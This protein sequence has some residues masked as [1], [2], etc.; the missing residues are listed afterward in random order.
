M[1]RSLAIAAALLILGASAHGTQPPQDNAELAKLFREDQ[2]D[3]MPAAGKLSPSV[4]WSVVI[5]RDR[6]REK[7]VKELIAADSLGTGSDYYHAA[8]VLQHAPTPDDYLLAHDL[9]V[10]A[11]ARGEE[12]PFAAGPVRAGVRASA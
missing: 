9:C 8:M 12:P 7:R 11:I 5:P 1:H 6:A 3:R 10:V 2:A 4:D